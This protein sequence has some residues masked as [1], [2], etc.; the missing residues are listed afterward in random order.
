MRKPVLLLFFNRPEETRQVFSALQRCRPEKLYLACDGPR[1]SVAG[2]DRI[3]SDLRDWVI[4]AID[5]ECEVATLFREKNL[6]CGRSVSGAIQWFFEQEPEGIILEDDCLP[7]PD[8]FTFCE[9][10]LDTYRDDTRVWSISGVNFL[11]GGWREEGSYYFSYNNHVWG[12][13][14]W[15]DRWE[16]YDFNVANISVPDLLDNYTVTKRM[17]RHHDSVLSNMANIDTWDYQW[18]IAMWRN[19]G[20]AILPNVN[21]IS[22][23]GFNGMATHTVGDSHLANIPVGEMPKIIHA[24]KVVQDY[25]ADKMSFEFFYGKEPS[26][27]RKFKGVIKG[28]RKALKKGIKRIKKRAQNAV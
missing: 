14:S 15:R 4:N 20:L 8:F 18:L 13:A 21:L 16:K 28:Y 19:K 3:V 11:E 25:N 5:W 2:E 17:L 24:D 26:S 1:D 23:I 22:N 10:L 9:E 6:G 27:L 7:A 12:W